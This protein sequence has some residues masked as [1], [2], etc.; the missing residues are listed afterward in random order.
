MLF[1]QITTILLGYSVACLGAG[2]LVLSLLVRQ[3]ES[4]KSASS[5]VMLA[6]GFI[7]GQGILASLWLLL[8][9]VG[10]F[11]PVLVV[12]I[13]TICILAVFFLS[14]PLWVAFR[15][16]AISLW[17]EL[18]SEPW[19]WQ[20]VAALTTVLCLGWLTSIGSPF[21]GDAVAFYMALPKVIAASHRLIPLP[22]YETYTNIG[23]QGELHYSVFMIFKSLD[24]ARLFAWPTMLAA[25]VMLLAI[26][27]RVGLGQRGQW[28]TLALVF[29]SSAVLN[30]SGDGKVDVFAAAP[31]VAAYYWILQIRSQPQ[32]LAVWLTGF[33]SGF[34]IA[35]KLSYM[36]VLAPGLLILFFWGFRDEVLDQ[37][38]RKQTFMMLLRVGVPIVFV[39]FISVSPQMIKNALLFHNPIAPFGASGI[40]WA[41]QVWFG[42]ET[43]RRIV[44]TYPLALVF[45]SYWGQYGNMSPLTLAFLPLALLLPKPRRLVD[46]PLAAVTI[47]ASA[48]LLC[49]VVTQ[50]S[51]IAPRYIL[52]TL[53]LFVLL[54]GRA[55]EY[56][57]KTE[58][59]PR[60]FALG[61]IISITV[62]VLT[63]GLYDKNIVFA[64]THT[65]TYL[66]GMIDECNRDGEY[67]Q[68][69]SVINSH[70]ESGDRVFLASYYRYWLRPDLLQCVSGT[71]DYTKVIESNTNEERWLTL[72]QEG[73]LYLLADRHT[74]AAFL[75][76]L[77]LD[78]PPAWV[79]LNLLY[80]DGK[81]RLYELDFNNPPASQLRTCRQIHPPAWDVVD[82]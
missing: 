40:G 25:A 27:R 61:I 80:E 3:V 33:F 69:T 28:I 75:D 41:K 30:M 21:S 11:S 19:G 50:P 63:V 66:T 15:N 71:G 47:S 59:P 56:I 73:F 44:L 79:E 54:P 24:A 45:G 26:G 18:R 60:L 76:N 17:R 72:Y 78:D 64:P 42:A 4:I 55:A 35:A 68:A 57:S 65:F 1:I 16:Q 62:N 49:W 20:M 10:W 2:I 34:A 74:H 31:G 43:T 14:V 70:A 82:R 12:G 48:G 46:S 77:N 13:S 39:L 36:V 81:L 29:A 67:C 53:L 51:V 32:R 8:A 58:T 38:K 7:L 52:A 9:L 5:G 23:L 22:G 6:T 37:S